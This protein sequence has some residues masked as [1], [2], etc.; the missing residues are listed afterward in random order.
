M[1]VPNELLKSFR[2]I[3][4]VCILLAGFIGYDLIYKDSRTKS[5]YDKTTGTI[6]YI[7]NTYGD[8]PYRDSGSY[9]YILLNNYPWPIELFIGDTYFKPKLALPDSL[10][11]GDVIT[12]YGYESDESKRDKVNRNVKFIDKGTM[13]VFEQGNASARA[14]CY[15]LL[16]PVGLVIASFIVYKKGKLQW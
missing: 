6:V 13:T 11:K 7:G 8:M 3:L 15:F 9:K 1:H 12:A 14:A 4:V 2:G 10:H 5:E 16:L